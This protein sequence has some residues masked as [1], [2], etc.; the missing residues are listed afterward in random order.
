MGMSTVISQLYSS[1][2]DESYKT[3]IIKLS[4]F[5]LHNIYPK[6]FIEEQPLLQSSERHNHTSNDDIQKVY[7]TCDDGQ[8]ERISEGIDRM[9]YIDS[10]K[11]FDFHSIDDAS[12]HLTHERQDH[13]HGQWRC[14][15]R[16]EAT[17]ETNQECP[18]YGRQGDEEGDHHQGDGRFHPITRF[19]KQHGYWCSDNQTPA[20]VLTFHIFLQ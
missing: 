12:G 5:S 11:I 10:L 3:F 17:R 9:F 14:Q 13:E 2:N 8:N 16:R 1:T 18:H 7:Q 15:A 4:T 19:L 6:P 20:W